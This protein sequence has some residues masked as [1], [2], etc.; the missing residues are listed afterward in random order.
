MSKKIKQCVFCGEKKIVTR[1]HVISR[2]LFPEKYE[3]TNLIIVPSCE[4]CNSGF[5]SDEEYFRLF[6]NNL[7]MEHS[8][9]SEEI[10]N[11]KIK[12]SIERRPQIGHKVKN[13]MELVDYFTKNGIYLGK[14]TK[15]NISDNDWDRYHNVLDKYI[16]GLFY[17]E[18]K[19]PMSA[20]YKIE[21]VLGNKDEYLQKITKE[22]NKW[23]LDN[24]EIFAYAHNS[25][26]DSYDSIWVTVYYNTIVF[27]S[28]ALTKEKYDEMDAINK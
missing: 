28:F 24:K 11:T 16:K 21:H 17:H 19:I 10:F 15:I 3:K 14:K 12:R 2:G 22:V 5:S 7:S 27:I 9:E 25:L 13:K 8:K 1:D 18:F 20:D 23:N 6:L 4:D 26:S